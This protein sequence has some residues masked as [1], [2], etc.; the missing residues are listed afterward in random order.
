[1]VAWYE[2]HWQALLLL[3]ALA[4]TYVFGYALKRR[5]L[6]WLRLVGSTLAGVAAM[7]LLTARIFNLGLMGQVVSI[8][9]LYLMLIGIVCLCNEVL[10]WTA[11]FVVSSGYIAQNIASHLKMLLRQLSWVEE[12]VAATPGVLLV[13]LLC[14]GGIYLLA[15]FL[16]QPYTCQGPQ[17]FGNKVKTAF[18]IVVLFICVGM[19]RLMQLGGGVSSWVYRGECIYQILCGCFILLLQYGLMERTQLAQSVETMRELVHQQRVQYDTSRESA[20][21]VEEKYHDLKQLLAGFRGRVPAEQLDQLE[22]HVGS[23]DTFVRTG[24]DVLDVILGEKRAL[25]AQRGILLTC[26]VNGA[27]LDFVEELDLYCLLSNALTN[28]M[29]AVVQLPE[30]ERFVTLTVVR[31]GSMAA[32]HVENPYAGT[33]ELENSLPKSRRDTQ[34][35]GFGMRSMARTVEK[36]DGSMAVKCEDQM[37][38]L[39]VILF[40]PVPARSC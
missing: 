18:S 4:G 39:D 32:I 2:D 21:L 40:Q 20:Q 35:H 34:Y 24:S 8:S 38:S 16:F 28:A 1:M 22:R 27:A 17:R 11:M 23:Y 5:P 10:V 36:Y 31:E 9:L 29:E 25:C 19:S 6:F 12:L 33:V 26:Y 37:F 14:Y 13:D 3:Q 15:F 30:G 7:E